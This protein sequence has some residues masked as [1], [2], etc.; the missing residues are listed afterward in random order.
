MCATTACDPRI[1]CAAAAAPKIDRI[2]IDLTRKAGLRVY[3]ID[4]WVHQARVA[5]R[6]QRRCA[7]VRGSRRG[8]APALPCETL[9]HP[10]HAQCVIIVPTY[11]QHSTRTYKS[12]NIV[13]LFLIEYSIFFCF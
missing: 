12:I 10:V 3:L 6:R 2:R 11:T 13:I 5:R 8:P 7:R 9:G 4:P 1:R